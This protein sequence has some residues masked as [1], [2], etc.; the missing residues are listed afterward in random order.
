MSIENLIAS[1]EA[2]GK[3]RPFKPRSR[4]KAQRRLY[5][6]PAAMADY[7]D[8]QSAINLLVGDGFV[9]AA[10]TR[11]TLGERIYKGF[12]KRLDPPPPEIWEMRVTE[13]IVQGR[14]LG[15]F[16]CADTLVLT[17]FHTRGLLGKRGSVAWASAMQGCDSYWRTAFPGVP[18]FSCASIHD[19][20]TEN[21]DDFEI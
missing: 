19:Y 14:L 4:H 15:R 7:D 13:P 3:L 1:L 2:A 16:A 8:P 10:M 11:W 20:V 12:I 5:L 21:C 6:S 9:R 17:K 18:I